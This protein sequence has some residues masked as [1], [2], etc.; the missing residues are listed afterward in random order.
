MRCLIVDDHPMTRDGTAIALSA[1]DPAMEIFQAESLLQAFELLARL[2]SIELVLLAACR[3]QEFKKL[4][5]FE[6]A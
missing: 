1:A 3:T 5:D 6:S 2:R 4:S